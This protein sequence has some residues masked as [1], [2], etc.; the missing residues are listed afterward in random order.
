MD[1][2]FEVHPYDIAALERLLAE[3]S[4]AFVEVIHQKLHSLYFQEYFDALGAKTIIVEPDYVDRDFLEDF[5]GYYVRCFP[6]YRRKCT[7]LHFFARPFSEAE[8][9]GLLS[10][11]LDDDH[12][13]G[14]QDDYLGFVVVKPLPQTVVGRT[15]LRTYPRNGHRFYPIARLRGESLWDPVGG[16]DARLSGTR[17]CGRSVRHECALVGVSRNR[18]A[19]PPPDTVTRRDHARG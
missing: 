12:V 3:K 9:E 13:R 11:A 18:E 10:R 15:C 2:P 14:L 16:G 7:R 5:A 17:Q 6:D 4:G 8:F 1:R 19:L